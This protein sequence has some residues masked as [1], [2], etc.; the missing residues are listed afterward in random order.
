[1]L[2]PKIKGQ[3]AYF[4]TDSFVNIELTIVCK[5]NTKC[6]LVWYGEMGIPFPCSVNYY[7]ASLLFTLQVFLL[8]LSV[9]SHQD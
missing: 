5:L 9:T 3:I 4:S 7:F 1:M 2:K 8:N 6:A